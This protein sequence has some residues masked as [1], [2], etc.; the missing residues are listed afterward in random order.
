[1]F[2]TDT[3]RG[4]IHPLRRIHEG[5]R[6]TEEKAIRVLPPPSQI[7]I[8]LSQ[9][10]GTTCEPLVKKGDRVLLGQAIGEPRG[11]VGAPVHSSISGK[12]TAIEQR[13]L[14]GG[15]FCQCVM[16]ENDGLDEK[17]PEL[18][19]VPVTAQPQVIIDRVRAAGLVGMG[20]AAFP[21]HIK[22]APP[23][24]KPVD[25]VLI[26]GAECEPYLSSDHRVMLENG[27][28]VID[29]LKYAMR[30]LGAEHGVI[31]VEKNKPLAIA[32]LQKLAQGESSIVV[33]PLKVKYPQGSEKQL[34]QAAVSRQVPS[35][36][37]P[38]DAGCVVINAS[39]SAA[40]ADAMQKG[41]PLYERVVT[42]AGAVASPDNLLVRIGTPIS[43]LLEACGGLTAGAERVLSGGPM[44]GIALFNLEV[45]IVKATSG[46][47]ALTQKQTDPG[48][49]T[50]CIHCGRCAQSCPIRLM[51]MK[52][53]EAGKRQDWPAA[54]EL[55]ALDC[56]ECGACS[57]VC[58]A[59]IELLTGIRITKRTLLAQRKR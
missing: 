36:G 57:Y 5:K 32:Q 41:I 14:S 38:A 31:A 49:S 46:I 33:C 6:E 53:H 22:L 39:T 44:M 10:A 37:L 54:A 3:F 11:F 51:P 28:K 45:P 12:V 58:P 35:G 26:N 24:E 23:K 27:Q 18:E 20:G 52:L 21:T 30:A 16:I 15:V 8:P 1:M 59:K 9:S 56:V 13:E 2:K 7:I 29:G 43:A 42:V 17:A 55:H 19:P 25:T 40:I 4:G 47:L 50:A 34:I 48:P